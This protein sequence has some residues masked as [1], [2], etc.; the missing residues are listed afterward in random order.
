MADLPNINL[1]SYNINYKRTKL[2]VQHLFLNIGR[3]KIFIINNINTIK[4]YKC[5]IGVNLIYWYVISYYI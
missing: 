3:I 4:K 1:C 5:D 2:K